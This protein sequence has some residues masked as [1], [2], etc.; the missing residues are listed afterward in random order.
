MTGDCI[1]EDTQGAYFDD[2]RAHPAPGEG[3]YYLIREQGS[4]AAGTYGTDSSLAERLPDDVCP[5]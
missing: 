4:C 3:F 5:S 2:T 1:V